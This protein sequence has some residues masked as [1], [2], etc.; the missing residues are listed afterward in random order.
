M[1]RPL[2]SRK[3]LIEFREYM[4]GWV[5]REIDDEFS[6]AGIPL[7]ETTNVEVKSG[8]RRYQIELYYASLDLTKPDDTAKLLGVF[9]NVLAT[10]TH[11][12]GQPARGL[13][14]WLEKDGYVYEG[15]RISRRGPS[16][17]QHMK[18][19]LG[20]MDNVSIHDQIRR[21][22]SSI[23]VDPALAIGS[24]KE[25]IESVCKTILDAKGE[26]YAKTADLSELVKATTKVLNMAPDDIPSEAKGSELV[27]RTLH[28]LAAV[29]GN[30]GEL[31]TLY[32]SG[33]GKGAKSK[34]LQPR[35]ARL[36]AG[37]ASALVTFLW[38][39]YE[40]RRA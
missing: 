35:H 25:L 21:I 9:E 11:S 33:H 20:A 39:T 28:N 12:D 6:A 3:T 38:D 31:R 29:V 1:L 7:A 34:G 26:T 19:K 30:I 4:T 23:D 16:G 27:K 24:A 37:A 15:G 32:G 40:H 2:I 36:V 17:M 5:L 14:S 13:V 22:E 8:A 18:S 10:T